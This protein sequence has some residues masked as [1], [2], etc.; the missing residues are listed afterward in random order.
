MGVWRTDTIGRIRPDTQITVDQF[1]TFCDAIK[2]EP[3]YTLN[4]QGV[5]WRDWRVSLPRE[6]RW[7]SGS[8]IDTPAPNPCG[9]TDY[10]FGTLA[11][12]YSSGEEAYHRAGARG[13]D[14]DYALRTWK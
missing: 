3:Y 10:Y 8:S 4:M 5:A 12:A 7:R 13:E 11:E 1:V 14:S 6:H 9:Y 2:A